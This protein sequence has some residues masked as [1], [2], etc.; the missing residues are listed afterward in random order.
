[1]IEKHEIVENFQNWFNWKLRPSFIKSSREDT[2][3]HV[4]MYDLVGNI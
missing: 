1:L 2:E 4:F 3:F